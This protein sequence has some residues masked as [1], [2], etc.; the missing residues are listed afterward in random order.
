MGGRLD[1]PGT[2]TSRGGDVS[3]LRA[4]RFIPGLW[5]RWKSEDRF[6]D[7]DYGDQ[8]ARAAP[9]G[10]FDSEPALRR[11]VTDADAGDAGLLPGGFHLRLRV[12]GTGRGV[13]GRS[14]AA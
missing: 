12:V 13:G 11:H 7:L 1:R 4:A 5:S 6:R 9:A 2:R 10:Q 8:T 3:Y 14:A